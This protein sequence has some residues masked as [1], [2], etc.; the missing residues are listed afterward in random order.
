MLQWRV[1]YRAILIV[2]LLVAIG[3]TLNERLQEQWSINRAAQL[4]QSPA[5][6][7][8][9][10]SSPDGR[11]SSISEIGS[12]PAPQTPHPDTIST[13]RADAYP[14]DPN[15]VPQAAKPS[16]ALPPAPIQPRNVRSRRAMDLL[17]APERA[18]PTVD[19]PLRLD[20]GQTVLVV[21]ERSGWYHV[22]AATRLGWAP[23]EAFSEP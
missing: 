22:N 16:A 18:A 19:P 11:G 2:L 13:P 6:S 4:D 15:V 12:Y 9:R 5:G 10:A 7:S 20:V 23:A 1:L 14:I 3:L 8:T 17:T 21:E